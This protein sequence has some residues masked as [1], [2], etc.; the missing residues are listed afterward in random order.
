MS[1]GPSEGQPIVWAV[2]LISSLAGAIS[3]G[4]G[5]STEEIL[6][7]AG[8]IAFLVF[9]W[10]TGLHQ[11]IFS[12]SKSKLLTQIKGFLI[13]SISSLF[14]L[15]FFL[16]IFFFSDSSI[17]N[18]A[19]YMTALSMLS[20]LWAF[21]LY[22]RIR[23]IED[24]PYA[25]LNSAA[26]GYVVLEG[27]VSLYDGEVA[28]GPDQR[29]PIM[30][31]YS[32]Y[33][34]FSSAGFLLDDGNGLCTV[35]PR[36]AEVITPRYHYDSYAYYA[37]YPNEAIYVIGQLKTLSKQRNEHERKALVSS[38]I[39]EWKRKPVQFLD[40][41]DKNKDGEVDD[42]EMASVRNAAD[43]RVDNDLEESYQQPASHVVSQPNDGRPFILSSIHPDKLIKRYK[44]AMWF[45]FSTCI[46]L[47]VF[48]FAMQAI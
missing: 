26:Q 43:K 46:I 15:T 29:L 36:D 14:Y 22:R 19:T 7:W 8:G 48:L 44:Y 32:K 1:F 13:R 16:G 35:D 2:L 25:R 27:K 17:I 12:T 42:M 10:A 6:F 40:H 31:W 45:H 5:S 39:V 41:F 20:L 34:Y 4:L 30:V 37:I 9:A 33:L 47:T 24:T 11:Y 23:L 38:K 18:K 28:R 3:F 21:L